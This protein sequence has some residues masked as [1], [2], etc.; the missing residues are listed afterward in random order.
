[1]AKARTY[2]LD[3]DMIERLASIM[4]SYEEIALVLNT[5]VDNL[6]K[7]Y[8]D[9][10]ERGRAEGKKGLRRAQYEKAVKDKDVRMLIFLGKQY[11]SQQDSPSETESN[12]PLPW[13]EDA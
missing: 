6:K 11:L 12:D 4:C 3:K 10:I 1:M 9:I 13:P 7:R 5:S 8:T 2:K